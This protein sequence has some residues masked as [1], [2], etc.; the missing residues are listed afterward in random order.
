MTARIIYG[1]AGQVLEHVPIARVASAS[2]VLEDLARD[3]EDDER[4][5]ASGAATVASWSITSSATA[6]RGQANAARVSTASTTGA[7]TGEPAVIEDPDGASE[8]FT[9]ERL[10]ADAYIQADAVLAGSYPAGST[11][12]GIKLSAAVPDSFAADEDRLK[13]QHPIAIVWTYALGG[14]VVRLRELVLFAR[15]TDAATVAVAEALLSAKALYPDMSERLPANASLEAIMGELA[16][17]VRDDLRQRQIQPEQLLTGP[18]GTRLLVEKLLAHMSRFGYAP[19]ATE[20]G[21]RWMRMAHGYYRQRLEALVI[22]EPG[23]ATAETTIAADTA[24][25]TPSTNYRG[26][27]QRM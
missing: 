1:E 13:D 2:F 7:A 20:P 25:S 11:V 4:V 24:P 3:D 8:L 17:E 15:H 21:E 12:R 10:S 14:Q 26:P 16:R 18:A 27:T 19:G 23:E 9:L 22:G 5:I 6:G